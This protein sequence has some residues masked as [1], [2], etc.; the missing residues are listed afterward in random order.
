MYVTVDD[1]VE[2]REII[3][4]LATLLPMASAK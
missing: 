2:R 3:E 4:Y 1:P